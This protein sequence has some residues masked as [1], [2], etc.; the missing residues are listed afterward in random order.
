MRDWTFFLEGFWR[1]VELGGEL[2]SGEGF[3]ECFFVLE[4]ILFR[5]GEEFEKKWE[6]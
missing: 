1:G 6:V 3:L 2:G 5:V 4:G